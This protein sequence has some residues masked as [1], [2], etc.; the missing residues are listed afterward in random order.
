MNK[1]D[2]LPKYVRIDISGAYAALDKLANDNRLP[3]IDIEAV[4]SALVDVL[5]KPTI[6]GTAEET[7]RFL[8]NE[9]VSAVESRDRHYYLIRSELTVALYALLNEFKYYNLYAENRLHYD[10][11]RRFSHTT[12]LLRR[13]A[14]Y[15]L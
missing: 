2:Q 5:F 1:I 6:N 10:Y 3:T 12:A 9:I 8:V 11:D 15:S 13:K 14:T 7:I 4:L